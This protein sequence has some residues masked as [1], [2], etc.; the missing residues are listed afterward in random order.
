MSV[1]LFSSNSH[2]GA[3]LSARSEYPVSSADHRASNPHESYVKFTTPERVDGARVFS[4]EL[5]RPLAAQNL[6]R[7]RLVAMTPQRHE[8]R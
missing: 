5:P 8:D 1:L 2:A 7:P 4:T 6:P 3:T